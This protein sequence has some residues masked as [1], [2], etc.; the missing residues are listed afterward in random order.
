MPSSKL[1][2]NKVVGV[3]KYSCLLRKKLVVYE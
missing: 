2:V 3:L 1:E